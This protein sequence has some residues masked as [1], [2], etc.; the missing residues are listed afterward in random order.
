MPIESPYAALLDAVP[1]TES[2]VSVLGSS[3][4]YWTYGADDAPLTIVAVHGFRGEHHGLDPV[5]AHLSG[6][7]VISPD[8]PG[9]GESTPLTEVDTSIEGYSA[10]L[11]GFV[12]QLGLTGEA[13]ILGHSFGSIVTSHAV[14]AGLQTP[15]LVLIN[16]IAAPALSGPKA[17]LTWLTVQYY[18][19]SAALPERAG[20][21][22]LGNPAIV[23]FT[24]LAMVTT[25]DP[26]LRR[27]IHDQ[28]DTYFSRYSDRRTVLAGFQ[29]SITSDVST[30]APA[31][32]VPTLLIAADR[33]PIT[34]VK[35]LHRLEEIFP[36]SSLVMLEG[37]GH[38]IHYERPREAAR[39]IVDFLGVGSVAEA[40]P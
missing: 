8:L 12:G 7:R 38:L 35:A 24:S 5:V 15:R 9:F 26:A 18:R 3:T 34:S 32:S 29:A 19:A 33:D 27:W 40:Q 25:K 1:V 2:E 21:A 10:W 20:L 39:A 14:A 31:I 6:V 16:P 36:N 23:R 22:L 28:H 17:F 13:I 11:T 4:R 30:A 37:V